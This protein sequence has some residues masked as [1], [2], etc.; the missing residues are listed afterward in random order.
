MVRTTKA[1][2]EVHTASGV[3]R[4]SIDLTCLVKKRWRFSVSVFVFVWVIRRMHEDSA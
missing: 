2:G 3:G 4:R 1:N